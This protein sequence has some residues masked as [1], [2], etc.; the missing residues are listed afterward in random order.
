MKVVFHKDFYS[1]YTFDSAAVAGRMEAIVREIEPFVEFIT[2]EPASEEDIAAVHSQN[3][4]E[5]VRRKGLYPI[6][7]LA[8]GAAILTAEIGLTEPCFGLIR[9]P[10]HHASKDSCWGFCFFNNMAIAIESLKNRNKIQTAYVLDIDMHFGDGTVN[11]IGKKA[12]VTVYNPNAYHRDDYLLEVQ[13]EMNACNVDIIGIS[14]GF[15]YHADDWGGV[16]TTDDYREIG[17][18]VRKAA[19]RCQAGFFAILEGGYNHNVLGKNALALIE[20]MSGK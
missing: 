9:P 19:K 4:I 1:V 10:G 8:A 17:A 15:D 3:H 7:S 20:G 14:A 18:M 12:Y 11:T 13:K 5:Y 6:A 16:L 2:P